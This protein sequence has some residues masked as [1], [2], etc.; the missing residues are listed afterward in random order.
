MKSLKNTILFTCAISLIFLAGCS[1]ARPNISYKQTEIKL[2]LDDYEI[3]KPVTAETTSVAILGIIRFRS[4]GYSELFEEAYMTGADDVINIKKVGV[5]AI[6]FL[7][8]VYRQKITKL[9]GTAIRWR[10]K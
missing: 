9:T 3:I 5:Q 1:T 4:K 7:G 6:N 10:K 8:F 2:D